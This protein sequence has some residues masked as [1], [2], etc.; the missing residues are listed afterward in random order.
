MHMAVA[1][2]GFVER[3]GIKRLMLILHPTMYTLEVTGAFRIDQP[4]G[5]YIYHLEPVADEIAAISSDDCLRLVNPTSLHGPALKVIPKVHAEV[6][7]LK[8]LEGQNFI[9]CTAGRDGRINI[10]DLR[11]NANVAELK[12][13]MS[14]PFAFNQLSALQLEFYYSK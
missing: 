7:C 12:T 2:T 1:K 10:W 6:T 9:V 13:S 14:P 4:Q 8:A 11:G 3:V 5:T